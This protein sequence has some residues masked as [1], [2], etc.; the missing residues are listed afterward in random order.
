MGTFSEIEKCMSAKF[1]Q[2]SQSQLFLELD[3]ASECNAHNSSCADGGDWG[4]HWLPAG[5]LG[6]CMMDNLLSVS[7]E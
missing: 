7:R 6:G 4:F 1:V 5:L 2:A 3:D